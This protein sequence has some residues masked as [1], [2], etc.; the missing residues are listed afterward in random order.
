MS[1][2]GIEHDLDVSLRHLKM[3]YSRQ[4]KD[5]RELVSRGVLV[6]EIRAL[7]VKSL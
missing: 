3:F 4:P 1:K 5:N 7:Q 6:A 2:D